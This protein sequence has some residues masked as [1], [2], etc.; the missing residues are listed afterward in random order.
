MLISQPIGYKISWCTTSQLSSVSLDRV[1]SMARRLS[2]SCSKLLAPTIVEATKSNCLLHKNCNI[3][4]EVLRFFEIKNLK[5]PPDSERSETFEVFI[6]LSRGHELSNRRVSGMN[7]ALPLIG[8]T[9]ISSQPC[10]DLLI[11]I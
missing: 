10:V 1:R 9:Q 3:K 6:P 2:S 8:I 7:A 11:Y 5:L 4:Q